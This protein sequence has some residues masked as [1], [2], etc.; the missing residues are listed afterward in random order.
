MDEHKTRTDRPRLYHAVGDGEF[1]F[2]TPTDPVRKRILANIIASCVE[3]ESKRPVERIPEC[4][5]SPHPF[6]QLY[7]TFYT[8]I[9]ASALIEQYSFAWRMTRDE[10]WLKRAREWLSAACRWEHSDRI[11][12]HFYTANRYMQALAVALDWLTG[13][14]TE[15]EEARITDVLVQMMKRWWPD[16]NAGRQCTLAGHHA[17]VDNGHFGVAALQ[18]LGRHPDAGEW[19]QAVVD[20]FRAAIMPN[21]CG[22]DGSPINGI[23]FWKGENGWMLHFADALRNVTGVDLCKEF[24]ERLIKP[25][26][27]IRYHLVPPATILP[28]RYAPAY[29]NTLTSSPYHQLDGFSAELLRLAQDAGDAELRDIALRDPMMGRMLRFG[30]GVKGSPAECMIAFG[31]YAYMYYDPDFKPCARKQAW[32]PSRKFSAEC[33]E[34]A[35]LRSV[36]ESRSL[37]AQVEG[38]GGV[39][40]HFSFSNLHVQWAGYPVLTSIGAF[41]ASPRSCGNMPCVGGQDEHVARLRDLVQS[42]DVDSV[43]V[44]SP[45]VWHEYWLLRGQTPLLLAAV[46]RRPRGVKVVEENGETFARLDGND[47]LQYPRDQYF[48]PDAGELRMRVRLSPPADAHRRRILFHTGTSLPPG[49]GASVNSFYLGFMGDGQGL[50]FGVQNQRYLVVNVSLPADVAEIRSGTWHEIAARWGGFNAPGG[51]PFIEVECDGNVVRCDD[52]DKFGEVGR[53]TIGLVRDKPQTFYVKPNTVLAFGAPV[54]LPDAGTAGDIS[55]ITLTCPERAPL[56]ITF[57]KGLAGETGSEAMI[58]KLNPTELIECAGPRAL[59]GAGPERIR[60]LGVLPGTE[61]RKETV[62]YYQSGLA[63]GS[64]T[65]LREGGES[66]STR[67]LAS[68]DNKDLLILLFAPEAAKARVTN[69][70]SG[71]E[72]CVDGARHLFAFQPGRNQILQHRCGPDCPSCG[73]A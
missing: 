1:Q 19:V 21:G 49:W 20:R 58:Y 53:D 27:Y 59:F 24:P 11:E 46:R 28:R 2:P 57:E 69:T 7:I 25:L 36:W 37:V 55:E 67:V 73:T 71:F 64:T 51:H 44:E 30:A 66:D 32:P 40:A 50:T 22:E 18:L 62:P 29:S 38:Y 68:C 8:G 33:G 60:V 14:L 13:A 26:L 35:I 52:P 16:V 3:L 70:G 6:H 23:A 72:L 34:S 48:N 10:R 9:E 41:E 4:P 47:Y 54:Q 63:A 65:S 45:R 12:E 56:Q 61:F 39:P 43:L 42:A 17:V 31:P 5:D 15:Q